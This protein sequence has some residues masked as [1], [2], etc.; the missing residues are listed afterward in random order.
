M[1]MNKDSTALQVHGLRTRLPSY[2]MR[3]LRKGQFLVESKTITLQDCI[4]EGMLKYI[5]TLRMPA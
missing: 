2:K 1:K 4:G 5:T 3:E